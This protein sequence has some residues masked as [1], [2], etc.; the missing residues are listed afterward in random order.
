MPKFGKNR[1][2]AEG[3]A[4]YVQNIKFI[5]DNAELAKHGF[6]GELS[7]SFILLQALGRQNTCQKF[8]LG[9]EDQLSKNPR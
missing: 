2:I 1:E 5:A 6:A 3:Q 7:S 4:D 9:C 8:P